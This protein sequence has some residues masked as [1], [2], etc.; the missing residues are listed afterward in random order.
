MWGAA[1]PVNADSDDVSEVKEQL[2]EAEAAEARAR[3]EAAEAKATAER[4][5]GMTAE[6]DTEFETSPG[7]SSRP[8]PAWWPHRG[9]RPRVAADGGGRCGHPRD[10]RAA[11][12]HGLMIWQHQRAEAQR[13]HRAELIN[14]AKLGVAALLSID[15]NHAKADVP[16]V[17]DLSTGG[18]FKND[19]S[20]V[21]RI[22]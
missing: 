15:Y 9:G 21:H 18:G 4:L 19:F 12:G 13:A 8:T 22:S 7:L 2:A 10:C 6:S 16:R 1:A 14:A 17:I 3:A 20:R 11:R 5:R